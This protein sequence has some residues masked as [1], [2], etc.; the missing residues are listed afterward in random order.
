M[1]RVTGALIKCRVYEGLGQQ[2]SIAHSVL[3]RFRKTPWVTHGPVYCQ[4]SHDFSELN[5]A[6]L[7][8]CGHNLS[9]QLS[10]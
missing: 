2:W 4:T 10:V 3:D 8:Y 9:G 5:A 1:M 7:K 6:I